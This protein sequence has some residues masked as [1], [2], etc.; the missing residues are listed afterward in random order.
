MDKQLS[1]REIGNLQF[2]IKKRPTSN[3][4]NSL[5]FVTGMK[6]KFLIDKMNEIE[7]NWMKKLHSLLLIS[8]NFCQQQQDNAYEFNLSL[9]S[10]EYCLIELKIFCTFI[11]NLLKISNGVCLRLNNF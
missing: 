11:Q 2:Q 10:V 9:V 1:N 5:R 7:Q 3:K 8:V 4:N 6:Q